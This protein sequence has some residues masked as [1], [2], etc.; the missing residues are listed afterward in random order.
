MQDSKYEYCNFLLR[1]GRSDIVEKILGHIDVNEI[2]S[3]E[4][5]LLYAAYFRS[6]NFEEYLYLAYQKV[7]NYDSDNKVALRGIARYLYLT[8]NYAEASVY[9]K[10]LHDMHPEVLS[11]AINYVKSELANGNAKDLL[12]FTFRLDYENEGN[13]AVK[14]TLAWVLL[15]NNRADASL[16][17]CKQIVNGDFGESNMADKL[18]LV[19][20]L[21]ISNEI[22]E[23]V[24]YLANILQSDYSMD[25]IVE[26]QNVVD[27]NLNILSHYFPTRY[28]DSRLLVDAAY[29]I[30]AKE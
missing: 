18:F 30:I 19:T 23:S 14:Q 2:R 26:L 25:R 4:Q 9:Y 22:K 20:A 11:Y 3:K 13:Y 6:R 1:H 28:S 24:G 16:K 5:A 12:N 27:S 7:L 15:C 10:K 21:W 17:M 8:D 29:S